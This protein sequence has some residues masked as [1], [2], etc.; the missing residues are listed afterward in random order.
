[1]DLPTALWT[2]GTVIDLSC[3]SA[4]HPLAAAVAERSVLL[5]AGIAKRI[6]AEKD[7]LIDWL[8]LTAAEA[9][10]IVWLHFLPPI[11]MILD[12]KGIVRL[13]LH[14]GIIHNNI[15][16]MKFCLLLFVDIEFSCTSLY[17]MHIVTCPI[18]IADK[19][20]EHAV[21]Y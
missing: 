4:V 2:N 8:A 12:R 5:G 16:S 7:A 1:M 3:I 11:I 9:G 21:G 13:F 6:P 18:I 15:I 10:K 17:N 14:F 19:G 20:G